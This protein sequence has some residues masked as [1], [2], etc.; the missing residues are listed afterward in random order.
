MSTISPKSRTPASD[1]LDAFPVRDAAGLFTRFCG[2]TLLRRTLRGCNAARRD[3]R[4]LT[5]ARCA[6][7]HHSLR[8]RL[9]VHVN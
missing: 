7:D 1:V 2:V 8:A 5:Y 9:L 6:T 3:W 4:C